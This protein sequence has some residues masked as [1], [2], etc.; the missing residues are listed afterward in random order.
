MTAVNGAT[1]AVDF[2]YAHDANGRITSI[3]DGAVTGQNRSFT[4]DGLGRL[5]SAAGPWGAGVFAYDSLGNLR[6]KTLGARVVD[7]EYLADNRI[8]RARDTNDGFVWR[9]YTHD[10]R[11]NVTDNDRLGFTYDRAEQPT[12][13]SGAATGAFTYDGNLKRAKQ[14]LGGE[15]VYSVYG[16]SGAVLYRDN[17]TTGVATD[18]IR[19]GG[20]TIARIKGAATS[21]LHADYLGSPVS[22]TTTGGNVS[23]REDYTPYGEERQDPAANDNDESFTGHIK[24]DATGLTYM[25]A[26]Y[27]DP[28]IGRF[29]SG[30]PVGFSEDAPQMFN[31]YSY[32]LNDPIN[33]FDPDGERTIWLQVDAWLGETPTKAPDGHRREGFKNNM[34]MGR[35]LTGGIYI[36]VPTARGQRWDLG[37]F[38]SYGKTRGVGGGVGADVGTQNGDDRDL[39]GKSAVYNGDLGLG[40]SLIRDGEGNTIGGTAGIGPGLGGSRAEITTGAVG[41]QDAASAI[42]GL[43]RNESASFSQNQD[44]SVSATISRAGS[45]I[46]REVTCSSNADGEVSCN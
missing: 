26:R 41:L 35:E 15:V 21:Y 22:A 46:S 31:R 1:K 45:R 11:G 7:I 6:Q 38:G 4:Y 27:F 9:N 39:D 17:I 8:N 25:Q 30:D 20:V 3:T 32:T 23:W 34:L 29:L 42:G 18:Y 12:A 37:I 19:A 36:S 33:A 13:I 24:D 44:G 10:A 43:F 28:V 5:A 16:Q 14:V 40:G 2:T